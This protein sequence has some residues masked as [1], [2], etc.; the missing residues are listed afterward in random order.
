M[1]GIHAIA[2][3]ARRR[4]AA[5]F[6]PAC[7]AGLI[8]V[9]VGTAALSAPSFAQGEASQ[10]DAVW[11]P[12]SMAG[13]PG[14]FRDAR[15]T[16]PYLAFHQAAAARRLDKSGREEPLPAQ[17]LYDARYYD[18]DLDLNP[19]TRI[20][21]GVVTARLEIVSGPLGSV[22][23][24]LGNNMTVSA[25]T[26]AG[27]PVTWSHASGI[28][29][30]NLDRSYLTG[31][32][33]TIVV[34]YAGNPAGGAWGWDTADGG[35]MIWTLSE[36]FGARTWWPCKDYPDDKADSVDIRVTVPTGLIVASNGSLRA[37]S[38][39]GTTA[40][41][42]WHESHPI[43][44]YLVSLA[45]HP[46]H[47]YNDW[48]VT[49]LGDSVEIEFY[50]W[51]SSIPD[52]EAV[53]A[54]VKTMMGAFAE[55]YGEYPFPDEKYGHAEFPWGGGM[56]HQTVTSLG[57]FGSSVVAH[58]LAHQWWG[59]MV[60]C[61]NFHD[62]WL[63]EGFATWSEAIWLESQGGMEAYHA[64]LR[65]NQYFGPGT[66][67]VP[68]T[69]DWGRIFDSNLSYNKASWIPHMLR[70]MLGDA[71]FFQALAEYRSRFEYA[72]ATTADFQ[73]VFEDISG[74]D[75]ETFFQQ[76]IYG[77]YY[78]IYQY[79]WSATPAASGYDVAVTVRQLQNWQLFAMPLEIVVETDQGPETF[80]VDNALAEEVYVL[81]TAGQ[82]SEVALDPSQWILR[83]VLA[84]IPTPTFEKSLLVVN[85]V[86]WD[87]YGTEIRTAYS[88]RVF[89]GAHDFAFWD[90]FATPSGG[91]PANVPAPLGHGALPGSVLGQYR[92]VVW[93]GNNY[94][95]D[96]S[97][98]NEAPLYSYLQ[99]GGNVYLLTRMGDSF[100]SG[101]YSDYLGVSWL[102]GGTIYDCISSYA[103][104]TN[105]PRLGTQN[106]VTAFHPT[107]LGPETTLLYKAVQGHTN[108]NW[109]LGA[110]R[111]PAEGGTY[112]PDGGRFAILMGRPY[113]WAHTELRTNNEYILT[114]LLGL[115][116]PLDVESVPAAAALS[117]AA[118]APN[119]FH[120]D[121]AIRFAL[122]QA[123]DAR[124]AV[125]D[126]QG[127]RV[128]TL[129]DGPAAAGAH[130]LRWSGEDGA[131]RRVATGV[132]F[133]RL[134]TAA[135]TR[136]QRLLHIR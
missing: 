33:A 109:G 38:D 129:L 76:W 91:Y 52:V 68:D 97:V 98:W 32:E 28:L 7:L 135:G 99:A 88:D 96:L 17:S 25:I 45:I 92:T 11:F 132:Y 39:N 124:L 77:E 100:L 81:H 66:I 67:Y 84:P 50:N 61:A 5:P 102:A 130:E 62:I 86:D 74:L 18:L 125:F 59:D 93:V 13:W 63:N 47:V 16:A 69:S 115:G 119:P 107:T 110:I 118:P 54:T 42:W 106:N 35:P 27:T 56:E 85:G 34:T 60:T 122:P 30:V 19:T 43:T 31:E 136:E 79:E 53:Q 6:W 12:P 3:T 114:N 131:G 116:S 8:L 37:Q 1:K 55:Q 23:L 87:T 117:L 22:V 133:L 78:P 26:C 57:Y 36:A 128:K 73:Q 48:Y 14:E 83:R 20:L 21:T 111:I 9:L 120:A 126:L 49:A 89:T 58:E 40:D 51:Q 4:N 71:L 24:D 108:P 46:Y 44:T 101:P 70:G 10:P 123:G 72:S 41:F 90:C 134:E 80:R 94:N 104:L 2:R 113:R 105:I 29:T 103:G 112:N 121:A 65:L 15:D 64:D 127:R 95:G 75:L 82:P